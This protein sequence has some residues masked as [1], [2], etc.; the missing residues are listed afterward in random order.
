MIRLVTIVV[1]WPRN[2]IASPAT[3]LSRS[4]AATPSAMAS[5]GSAGVDANLWWSAS[6]LAVS[7]ATRSVNVPPT[8]MPARITA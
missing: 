1:P 3:P 2:A 6:P 7:T 5:T 8:S 4:S